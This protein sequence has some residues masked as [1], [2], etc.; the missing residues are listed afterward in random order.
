MYKWNRLKMRQLYTVHAQI[1]SDLFRLSKT[2]SII[3]SHKTQTITIIYN[4]H[5][6]DDLE[7]QL[8]TFFTIFT[9]YA[10]P[11]IKYAYGTFRAIINGICAVNKYS[12]DKSVSSMN[13]SACSSAA[14]S[15][16]CNLCRCL[17]TIVMGERTKTK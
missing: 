13:R 3:A 2:N 9:A 17:V 8:Q 16:G 4:F 12:N 6:P 11:N 7:S 1:L 15:A 10:Q 5:W 14:G